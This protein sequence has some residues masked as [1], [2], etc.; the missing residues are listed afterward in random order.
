MPSFRA[1]FGLNNRKPGVNRHLRLCP[2]PK[3]SEMCRGCVR[4]IHLTMAPI[5]HIS[6]LKYAA[7]HGTFPRLLEM[8]KTARAYSQQI[9]DYLSRI[10]RK[11][12]AFLLIVRHNTEGSPISDW[13]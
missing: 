12:T 2:F 4:I 6:E 1:V 7:R 10:Q 3:N 5:R 13:Q 8:D 9:Y 11:T